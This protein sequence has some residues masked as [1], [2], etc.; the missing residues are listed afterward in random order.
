MTP[1]RL[2]KRAWSSVSRSA[3]SAARSSGR[4]VRSRARW[5]EARAKNF[6]YFI[7]LTG[8]VVVAFYTTATVRTLWV[9]KDGNDTARRQLASSQQTADAARRSAEMAERQLE[10][11]ERPWVYA[12]DFHGTDLN[13]KTNEWFQHDQGGFLKFTFTLKNVGNSVAMRVYSAAKVIPRGTSVVNRPSADYLLEQE[14][15]VCDAP[16][17]QVRELASLDSPT[18]GGMCGG[19]PQGDEAIG[20]FMFPHEETSRE[21]SIFVPRT[22][23]EAAA[24]EIETG[25]IVNLLLVT[26]TAYQ[27]SFPD[28]ST[29]G[30]G[31]FHRMMT[32][33][34]VVDGDARTVANTSLDPEGQYQ[35]RH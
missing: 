5:I 16:L 24:R 23:V 20:D 9:L 12:T 19:A 14:S 6:R 35:P 18:A 7:Q 30:R 15:A 26:C 28:I 27:F 29:R 32:A 2:L 1:L 22:E 10:L 4:S 33:F 8:V 3:R 17:E 13:F 34:W 21:A 11:S 25:R 31:P